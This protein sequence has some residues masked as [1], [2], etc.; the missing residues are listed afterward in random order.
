VNVIIP[1]HNEGRFL[2]SCLGSLC[3]QDYPN[4]EIILVDNASSD[5]TREICAGFPDVRYIYYATKKSSY[6]A[7]NEGVRQSRGE[8]VAFFD[9]DQIAFP[10]YLSDL[11]AE[12]VA[13]DPHHVYVGRLLD[14]PRVPEVLRSFF[15]WDGGF[16]NLGPGQVSTCAVAV[17]RALFD[18]LGGFKEEI[19]SGGD[20][21]F[22]G[23]ASRMCRVHRCLR[24][25]GYHYW[26]QSV[27]DHL[28]REERYAF[29]RCLRAKEAGEDLPPV[30]SALWR[31]VA[32]ALQKTSAAAAV[33][34][35]FPCREWRLRWQAQLV[36]LL[37]IMY[38]FRGIAKYHLG[39]D[40]AGDLPA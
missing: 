1:T 39:R 9:A 25:G 5:N 15:S 34:F 20:F 8:V 17:P 29:G 3:T 18:S 19:L 24:Y 32:G 14:D 27:F 12:Y 6:A 13:D 30:R 31:V 38:R 40:R 10:T 7:R 2:R 28:S 22:F 33:P 4:Y 26:A 37:E 11:L 36:H 21:E 35:R 23:R 16:E